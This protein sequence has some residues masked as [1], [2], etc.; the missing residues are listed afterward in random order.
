M[1]LTSKLRQRIGRIMVLHQVE[2]RV[3]VMMAHRKT[4]CGM[5]LADGSFQT[6]SEAS[7]TTTTKKRS[8]RKISQVVL[9]VDAILVIMMMESLCNARLR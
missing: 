7:K 9:V 5:E 2:T 4:A 6:V 1:A 8:K 3:S